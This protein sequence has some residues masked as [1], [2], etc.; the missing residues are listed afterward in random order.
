MNSNDCELTYVRWRSVRDPMPA[1]VNSADSFETSSLAPR[2]AKLLHR[3]EQNVAIEHQLIE[4]AGQSYPWTRV[5]DPDR[6]LEQALQS[7]VDGCPE[8]DPF[9]AATWRAA[10]GLERFLQRQKDLNETEVLELGGGSGRAGIA[11][12][13]LGA[14]VTITDASRLALMICRFNA[15]SLE[16]RIRVRMLNWQSTAG[17]GLRFPII[18]GSDIVYNPSLYPILEPCLRRCLADG[19]VVWLSEPQRHTGDRFQK[20]IRT[21]GWNCE[22]SLVDLED[23]ERPIRI[24]ECRLL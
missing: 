21:A 8:H 12:A 5:V 16:N 18:I 23:G 10:I 15:R 13:I 14:K 2:Y 22:S 9:W 17:C 7:G 1:S 24:F 20:W 11:A 19:G 4:I 6:L 3:L